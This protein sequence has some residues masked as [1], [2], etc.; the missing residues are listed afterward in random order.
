MTQ[1][2]CLCQS[3]GVEGAQLEERSFAEVVERYR[4]RTGGKG[5][6]Q[7]FRTRQAEYI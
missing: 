3:T 2:Q 1:T 5:I 7:P 6:Y 4:E